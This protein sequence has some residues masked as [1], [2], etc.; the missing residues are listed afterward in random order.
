MEVV[1]QLDKGRTFLSRMVRDDLERTVVQSR[2][3]DGAAETQNQSQPPQEPAAP[4]RVEGPERVQPESREP[5]QSLLDLLRWKELNCHEDPDRWFQ[6]GPRRLL[7]LWILL[8]R[9]VGL[10]KRSE[11]KHQDFFL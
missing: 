10:L 8:L 3:P 9:V 2:E 5:T 1:Q 6:V 4:E 11:I 7:C